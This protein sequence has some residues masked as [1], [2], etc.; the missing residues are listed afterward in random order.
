[1]IG[2]PDIG[3]VG[4]ALDGLH[5]NPETNMSVLTQDVHTNN[6]IIGI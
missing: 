2:R 4:M 5:L 6:N 1:M 3:S